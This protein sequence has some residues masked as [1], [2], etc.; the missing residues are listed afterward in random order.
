MTLDIFSFDSIVS[1]IFI[2]RD[3]NVDLDI[4]WNLEINRKRKEIF[5]FVL[6]REFKKEFFF[7]CRPSSEIK[8]HRHHRRRRNEP[9]RRSSAVEGGVEQASFR[10]RYNSVANNFIP[11]SRVYKSIFLTGTHT[12]LSA[13]QIV[14]GIHNTKLER[15]ANSNGRAALLRYRN[16]L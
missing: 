7:N 6:F 5:K 15:C 13:L 3:E 8:Y 9:L 14:Q 1:N 10:S 12:S 11:T 4:R 16:N 2:E